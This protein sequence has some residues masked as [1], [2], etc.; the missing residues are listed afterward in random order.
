MRGQPVDI[1]HNKI[2][3]LPNN[4]MR[5]RQ[6]TVPLISKGVKG[7]STAGYV[8]RHPQLVLG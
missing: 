6:S 5:R 7:L 1:G 2:T 4:S 3:T 8:A